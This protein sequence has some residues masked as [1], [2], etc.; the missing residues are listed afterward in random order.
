[1]LKSESKMNNNGLKERELQ[2]F[3]ELLLAKRNELLSNVSSMEIET[4]RRENSDL[5]M[6]PVHTDDMGTDNYDQELTLGLMDYERRLL[7]DIDE[8]LERI[9]NGSYGLCE[10]KGEVIPKARLK[11]VPWAKYCVACATLMEKGLIKR[12]QSSNYTQYNYQHDDE[13]TESNDHSF[14]HGEK[15]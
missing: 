3:K 1:V 11:A 5:S 15:L 10:G 8:A 7:K 9:E 14:G 2:E 13:H 12:T 6:F 4:L